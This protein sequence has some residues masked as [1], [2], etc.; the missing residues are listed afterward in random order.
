M[1]TNLIYLACPYSNKI[2]SIKYKRFKT[3]NKVA[4]KLMKKGYCIFS[5][6][7][8][9]TPIELHGKVH[10][11]WN[12]W[13]KQDSCILERCD[14]L[15]VLKLRGWKKSVGVTAEIEIAKKLGIPIKYINKKDYI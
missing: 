3:V 14:R 5:P 4:A 10:G 15:F 9:S 2:G 1:K 8:H 13:K 12:F 6:I 7:S 11:D